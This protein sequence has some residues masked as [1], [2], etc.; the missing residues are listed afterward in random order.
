[1]PLIQDADPNQRRSDRCYRLNA[2]MYFHLMFGVRHA[3]TT[4]IN[5]DAKRSAPAR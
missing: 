2:S 1:M 4:P 3:E 5:L